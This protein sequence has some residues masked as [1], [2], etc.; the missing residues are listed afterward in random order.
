MKDKKLKYEY[1]VDSDSA[2]DPQAYRVRQA[3]VRP[4]RRD[5]PRARAEPVRIG[6]LVCA[7]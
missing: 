2:D 3:L 4:A 7:A 5:A 6:V 1:H